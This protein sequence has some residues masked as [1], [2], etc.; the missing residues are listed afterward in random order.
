MPVPEGFKLITPEVEETGGLPKGYT[1]LDAS[2]KTR[3]SELE[4]TSQAQGLVSRF[5]KHIANAV[6]EMIKG[7]TTQSPFTKGLRAAAAYKLSRM[8][9]AKGKELSWKQAR[10]LMSQGTAELE[11]K[12][13]PSFDIPEAETFGEKVTDVAAGITTTI[14]ELAALKKIAPGV[15]NKAI[16]EIQN[17][18]NGGTPGMGAAMHTMFSVPS[19]FIPG[20]TKA[21]AIAR[22]TAEAGLMGGLSAIEQKLST[23]EIDYEKV[24]INAGLPVAL[25][26]LGYVKGRIKAGDKKIVAAAE[27]TAKEANISL[28]LKIEPGDN[29][30]R[31]TKSGKVYVEKAGAKTQNTRMEETPEGG[32]RVVAKDT[33]EVLEMAQDLT[34]SRADV[35]QGTVDTLLNTT[36]KA[37]RIQ[38][39][40]IEPLLKKLHAEQIQE[41]QGVF[42]KAKDTLNAES[43]K[44]WEE[45]A[46]RR[47]KAGFKKKMRRPDIEPPKLSNE[48]WNNISRKAIDVYKNDMFKLTNLQD[49]LDNLRYEGRIPT[50]YEF[51]LLEPVLGTSATLKLYDNLAPNRQFGV[52]DIPKLVISALKSPFGFD[53]QTP[54]QLIAVASKYPK[55][56]IKSSLIN[57]HAY[58]SKAAANRYIK[59]LEARPSWNEAKDRGLNLVGTKP[60]SRQ[61]RL[62]QYGDWTEFLANRKNRVLKGMGNW[63]KASE[64]G[65]TTGIDSGMINI[66]EAEMKGLQKMAIR[67]GWTEK[68][69]NIAAKRKCRDI[70]AFTK[71]V[72]AVN[73]KAVAIQQAANYVMFSPAYTISRPYSL[74]RALTGIVGSGPR[75]RLYASEIILRNIATIW[76]MSTIGALAAWK[77]MAHKPNEEPPVQG[78][79]NPADS[80]WGKLRVGNNV[81]D[82]SFGEASWYRLIARIGISTYAGVQQVRNESEFPTALDTPLGKIRTYK[83]SEEAVRYIESRETVALSLAKTLLTGKDWLGKPTNYTEELTNAAMPLAALKDIVDAGFASGLWEAM[84]QGVQ[85]GDWSK[86]GTK[87]L[88]DIPVGTLGFAGVGVMSYKV[89]TATT[90]ARFR[91]YLAGK[92]YKKDWDSLRPTEQVLLERKYKK[93]LTTMDKKI[94]EERVKQPVDVNRIQEEERRADARVRKMLPSEIQLKV[95][96]VSLGIG[97]RPKN[98]YLNDDRYQRYQQLVSESVKRIFGRSKNPSAETAKKLLTIAKNSAWLQLKR[99]MRNET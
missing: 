51:G 81:I 53:P 15:G 22:L 57:L 85:T 19:K 10:Q 31:G 71:R 90:R 29:V 77:H 23:G 9:K 18:L 56:F 42:Q 79:M 59:E 37:K 41:A 74:V 76:G 84:Y 16:W 91:D 83:T 40:E 66:Y 63:L 12:Y 97:R 30:Y 52:W 93:Q 98:F 38:K 50:P 75:D 67:K 45:Q 27:K 99:E 6:P 86:V 73:P 28:E 78:S 8:V 80:L 3:L 1:I 49:S 96:G 61:N 94:A 21:A 55:T 46:I 68:Q 48:Q 65:A 32:T 7:V 39:V 11:D 34:V 69:I 5:G 62:Q 54:R 26:T 35:F 64:R 95:A 14:A 13:L 88:Q 4:A 2:E 60:W 89:P 25:H 17:L 20:K 36:A 33:G 58:W 87:P 43:Y 92:E 44:L 82:L 47:S 24:A 70:N 72:V